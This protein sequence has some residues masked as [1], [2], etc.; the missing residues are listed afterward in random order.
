MKTIFSKKHILHNSL[1]ELS[2]GQLIRP[3]EN[4]QRMEYI[5]N[6]ILKQKLGPVPEP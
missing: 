3:Y 5:L 1:T 4:I 6:E 2:G